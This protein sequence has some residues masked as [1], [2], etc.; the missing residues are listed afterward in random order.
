MDLRQL[1]YFVTVAETGSISAAA[2]MLHVAQSAVSRQMRRLEEDVGGALFKRSIAGTALTDSGTMLL[3][4][5]RFILGE[6][7]SAANDVSVFNRGMRG[8][9]RMAAPGSVGRALY[10]P[11]VQLFR[12]QYSHVHLE[13]TETNTA[14]V[15]QRLSAGMLDL[16]IVSDPG[17]H[18]HLSFMPL[19]REETVLL[20]PPGGPLTAGGPVPVA[21]LRDLPIIIP[22]GLRRI[23]QERF[24]DLRPALQIDGVG[25]TVQLTL[26][27]LGYAVLPRSIVSTSGALE[28][29][30]AVPIE[31]FAISRML[32]TVKGRPASLAVRAFR[33]AIEAEVARGIEAGLFLAV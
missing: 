33:A 20:C 5:A 21:A 6:V 30:V 31:G 7:E 14:D 10:V 19:L 25:A 13:L 18:E 11:T 3:E 12:A 15:L 24:G 26:A 32:A 28:P 23:F 17:A 8:T 9:V 16:G 27:G 2:S 4:R 22:A 29:L 1:R